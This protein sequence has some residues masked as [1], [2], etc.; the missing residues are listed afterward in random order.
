MRESVEMPETPEG[1]GPEPAPGRQK[2]TPGRQEPG[3]R[4]GP[5]ENG[6]L[7]AAIAVMTEHGYHGT[8]VRDIA[9][10]AGISPAALYYHFESKQEVL[11]TIMERGIET[12]L[13]AS[14][15]ALAE[16]GDEP[17]A[18]LG[19]LVETHVLFHLQDQRGTMLGTSELRA[20]DEPVRGRHIAKRH[21]QQRLF[22]GVITRGAELGVFST[23]IPL[24]AS[25]AIVVMCTG[26]AAWFSPDG[27]LGRAEIARN[28]RRLALDMVAARPTRQPDLTERS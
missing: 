11:A 6:I 7:R 2:P 26:V 23:P 3:P 12:L 4:Q 13:R 9:M 18:G 10:R 17:A 8:S 24:E 22:D 25:R 16:A 5:G 20:L 1:A 15:A 14:R 28:Y 21:Q 27:P 19:T